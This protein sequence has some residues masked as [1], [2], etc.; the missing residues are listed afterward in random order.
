MTWI[1]VDI[2]LVLVV[3]TALALTL[4]RVWRAVRGLGRQVG[5]SGE[6]VAVATADLAALQAAGLPTRGG[7]RS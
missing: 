7:V 4:L 2:A 5:R 6:L 1:V 3:L